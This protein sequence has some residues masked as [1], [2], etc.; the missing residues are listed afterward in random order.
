ME[1]L[2]DEIVPIFGLHPVGAEHFLKCTVESFHDAICLV[3]MNR[4]SEVLKVAV[5]G[6]LFEFLGIED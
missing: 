3:V 4:A 6:E 5:L 1:A 2:V